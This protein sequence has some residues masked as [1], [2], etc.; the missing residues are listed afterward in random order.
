MDTTFRW[1]D[2]PSATDAEWEKIDAILANKGWASLNRPTTR[3]LVVED[4]D[5]ILGFIC[6]QLFPHTEPLYVTPSQRGTGLAKELSDQ[7]LEYLK[8]VEARGWM[9]IADSPFAAE[10]CEKAGMVKV[11]APVYRTLA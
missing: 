2:G 10:M 5:R 4:G 6:L 8:K 7:M 9:A 1:I 3:L 11:D